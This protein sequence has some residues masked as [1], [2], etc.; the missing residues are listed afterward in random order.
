MR[1]IVAILGVFSF[2]GLLA[3]YNMDDLIKIRNNEKDLRRA[4]LDD[5]KLD[6]MNIVGANL[7][8]ADLQR[9]SLVGARLEGSRLI[10]ANLGDANLQRANLTGAILINARLH[11]ADVRDAILCGADLRGALF[12]GAR[13]AGADFEAARVDVRI[14]SWLSNQKVKNFEKIRWNRGAG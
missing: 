6:G 8:D 1:R 5:A 3:A 7:D 10:R 12:G 4:V 13:V 14:Q 9:A 2:V 11:G